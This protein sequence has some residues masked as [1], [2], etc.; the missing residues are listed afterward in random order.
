MFDP[1]KRRLAAL[2]LGGL[3]ACAF[4]VA[5]ANP[6]MAAPAPSD[7]QYARVA[8][9]INGDGTIEHARGIIA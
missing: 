9:L 4:T 7:A 2:A 8:G 1:A 5:A 3:A 6:A